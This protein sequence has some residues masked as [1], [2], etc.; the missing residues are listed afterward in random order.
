[1]IQ[2]LENANAFTLSAGQYN[3]DHELGSFSKVLGVAR[4]MR[5]VE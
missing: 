5:K 2:Q 3:S 1:M 4:R